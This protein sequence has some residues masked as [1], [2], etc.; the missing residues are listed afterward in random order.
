MR[1]LSALAKSVIFARTV[2]RK[3]SAGRFFTVPRFYLI[4]VL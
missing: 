4:I 3:K 1:K 2:K